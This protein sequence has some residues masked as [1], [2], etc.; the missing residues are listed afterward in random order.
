MT[1]NIL[2]KRLTQ[3]DEQEARSIVRLLLADVFKL[4]FTD[5]CCGALDKLTPQEQDLLEDKMGALEKGVPVQYV[6]GTAMFCDRP[7][8][9]DNAVLIPRPETEELCEWIREWASKQNAQKIELL[10]IGTGSGCIAITTALDVKNSS[11]TAWDISS[12]ALAVANTN[13]RRHG[14]KVDFVLQDALAAPT[15]D[16]DKWDVVVSNPPYICSKEAKTM[17][18]NVLDHEPHL[19]LFVPDASP[20]LFYEAI[21]RYG[22]HALKDNGAIFFEINPIYA[23]ETIAMLNHIGYINATVKEDQFGKRRM[24]MA[25]K[26]EYTK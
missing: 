9:V 6:T 14:A 16:K 15:S 20:L 17:D 3:Y 26:R 23:N 25:T 8:H 2:S 10:D 19:A 13:A 5:I 4:S 12:E 21:A 11:V 24:V 7:F 18:A 22:A 1:L